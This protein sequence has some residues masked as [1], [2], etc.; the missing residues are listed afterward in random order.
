MELKEI[1]NNYKTLRSVY[2]ESELF[3]S[4]Q[5]EDPIVY[6]GNLDAKIMIIARDLDEDEVTEKKPL[7][8]KAGQILRSVLKYYNLENSVYMTN[9]VPYKP[10]NNEVFPSLMRH[11]FGELLKEQIQLIKPTIIILLGKEAI[12]DAIEDHIGNLQQY[13]SDYYYNFIE[14]GLSQ[15]AYV[16]DYNCFFFPMLHPSYFVEKD[17][18]SSDVA[19]IIDKGK[20]WETIEDLTEDQSSF[21]KNFALLFEF[22][23]HINNQGDD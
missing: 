22:V 1:I 10:A 16:F 12:Q 14:G 4:I 17:I 15:K 8:G 3:D 9:L 6:D 5:T 19:P 13:V 18:S 2:K 23:N 11:K 20:N 21:L 7:I